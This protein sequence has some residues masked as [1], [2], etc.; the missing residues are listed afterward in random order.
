MK[1]SEVPNIAHRPSWPQ[2]ASVDAR[3]AEPGSAAAPSAAAP[4]TCASCQECGAPAGVHVLSGYEKGIPVIRRMCLACSEREGERV[5]SPARGGSRFR[6]SVVIATT[7]VAL[8]LIAVLADDVPWSVH[9]G[10]GWRQWGGAGLA[11]VFVF[12]GALVGADFLLLAGVFLFVGSVGADWLGLSRVSG[13]GWKQQLLLV[14]GATVVGI[15]LCGR[16]A[17]VTRWKRNPKPGLS[18]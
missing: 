17:G 5:L 6:P 2:S 4:S 18:K 13:F 8:G 11:A 10:F 9:A 12:L 3:Q 14:A 16:L 15:A 7:G 1:V